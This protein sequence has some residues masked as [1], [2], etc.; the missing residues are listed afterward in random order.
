[1][2]EILQNCYTLKMARFI[3]HY[4]D[5]KPKPSNWEYIYAEYTALRENKHTSFV[6]NM[7]KQINFLEAKLFIISKCVEVLAHAPVPELIAELKAYGF[8]GRYNWDIPKQYSEELNRV[9]TGSKRFRTQADQNKKELE[10]YLSKHQHNKASLKK[11]FY[12]MA[13]TLGDHRKSHV[14]LEQ[15]TVTEWCIMM[16]NY[17]RYCEVKNAEN[18]N[19][20]KYGSGR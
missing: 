6:L 7:V 8:P 5:E 14:D 3:E 2:T 20:L 19:K 11:D 16:N 13:I 12:T 1:M 17:D 15:I 18:N 4:A 9:V 10:D